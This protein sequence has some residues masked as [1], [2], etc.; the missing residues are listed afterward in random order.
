MDAPQYSSEPS[1]SPRHMPLSREGIKAR[2]AA[3][4]RSEL[5]QAVLRVAIP[6]VAAVVLIAIWAWTGSLGPSG[7]HGLYIAIVFLFFAIAL[8]LHIILVGSDTNVRARRILGIIADNVVNTAFMLVMDEGGAVVFGVYLFVAFGNGFRYGRFYLHLSQVLAVI[9]FGVV[10]VVSDFWSSNL[11]AGFGVLIAMIILPF[12]V[13]VLAERI[14]EAKRKA[15]EANQAKSRFLAN[16]SHEMRTPL[17]GVIAMAD[18]LR[19]TKLHDSQVEI[20]D[21]LATSAQLALTQVEDV[22]DAAKIEAGRILIESRPFNLSK[23]VGETTKVVL[24]QARYKGLTVNTDVANEAEAWFVGDPHHLGQV[25]LNLLSNAVKFTEKGS[26]TLRLKQL[27]AEAESVV[28]RIEVEDSGIGIPESKLAAIFEPFAQADDSITRVY[29]GTGLGTTIARQLVLLMGG[30]IGV[31]SKE[32]QGSLFWIEMPLVVSKVAASDFDHRALAQGSLAPTRLPNAAGATVHKL[33]GARVLVAE[34]NATNQRVT[35]LILQSRGHVATIVA[36]GDEAL[37]ALENGGFDIALFDLSMPVLSGLE[38]LKM[39]RF[40]ETKPIP[41]LMLSANVTSELIADCEKAGAA[42]FLSKPVRASILLDA[43]ERQLGDRAD[44]LMARAK[45][46]GE[47]PRPALT[48]VQSCPFD[49]AVLDELERLSSDEGFVARLLKGFRDDCERLAKQIV[50]DLSHRRYESAKDAIHALRGGSG[51]VGAASLV[52][53]AT[54]FEKL[55]YEAM[56]A[57]STSLTEELIRLTTEATA[58]IDRHLAQ[59]EQQVHASRGKPT[60]R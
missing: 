7:R 40:T 13:G 10:L 12:Y 42:E 55:D 4:P 23:L 54:M 59:R 6:F 60:K 31:V 30:R 52:H 34:D 8:T 27:T 44:I 19:E 16:V 1:R 21:T 38:A 29:G 36:N 43:I 35:E 39:Y 50:D 46:A 3:A 17:N 37:D 33:R 18:L 53:Y 57:R 48:V 11:A 58:Y 20:V 22:L 26:V 5:E 51:G 41:V 24:P 15:D 9:G 2:L 25:L 56:R 45:A 14:T 32:H 28:F 47:M 49:P